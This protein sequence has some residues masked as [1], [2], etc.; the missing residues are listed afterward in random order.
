MTAD[1]PEDFTTEELNKNMIILASKSPRRREL[2]HYITADFTAAGSD[3]DETLPEGISPSDAVL[4]L[5]KIKAEPYRNDNDIVIGADTVVSIDGKILGK[6]T[7]KEH[8]KQM[9]RS[10]SG[11]E[12]S[13]FTGITI[14]K[15]SMEKLFYAETRVKFFDLSEKEISD[16]IETGEP[17]D[18]AGAYG[19]QGFG[20]L[21]VEK[22]DGDYFNVVGLPV[23]ILNKVLKEFM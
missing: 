6:P 14:I 9:L 12:H 23:S 7:D 18:K 15:G 13:V 22:I 10:L 11:R 8:A 21:L 20:S 19:I 1:T 3:V 2:M 4:Y 5:S 16:Y 17:M